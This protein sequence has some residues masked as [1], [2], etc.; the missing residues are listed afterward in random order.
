MTGNFIVMHLPSEGYT[1][2]IISIHPTL[3]L[4]LFLLFSV[5]PGG[6]PL[7]HRNISCIR[8]REY[9][10][11]FLTLYFR[12]SFS[13]RIPCTSLSH[14]PPKLN[15]TQ[16]IETTAIFSTGMLLFLHIWELRWTRSIPELAQS[17]YSPHP[18]IRSS[19]SAV[20]PPR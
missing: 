20:D 5:A 12:R 4:R 8:A 9:I 7:P 18:T 16:S 17:S 10:E 19:S 2:Y 14:L 15:V 6:P 3:G 11:R 13:R 1:R